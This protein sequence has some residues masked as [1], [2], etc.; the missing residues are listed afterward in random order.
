VVLMDNKAIQRAI[1]RLSHEII[2]KNKGVKGLVLIGIHTRGV[3]LAKRIAENIEKF[4]NEKI[5]VD[6]LDIT[7][8]R[9]DLEK[10][11]EQPLVKSKLNVSVKDK[12]VVLVDDVIFTGRTCRA[13]M[14]A[15]MD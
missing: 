15:V 6:V 12:T 11:T 2:E 9:D 1:T 14:N 4:E 3:P 7:Y 10:K 5:T 8:Y 13:A